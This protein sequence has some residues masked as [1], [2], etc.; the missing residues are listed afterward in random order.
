MT[1]MGYFIWIRNHKGT[2]KEYVPVK[3]N[4][5]PPV[6]LCFLVN[7]V[8]TKVVFLF[9]TKENFQDIHPHGIAKSLISLSR[10]PIIW[11][12]GISG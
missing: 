1:L 2:F 7:G 9:I 4:F 10:S 3:K 11:L 12:N 5:T 6:F 8:N